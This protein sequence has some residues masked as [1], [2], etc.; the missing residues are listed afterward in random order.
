MGSK[1]QFANLGHST[2]NFNFF[3]TQSVSRSLTLSQ[4]SG[5]AS[6]QGGSG[7]LMNK[8]ISLSSE[9]K[10]QIVD[11]VVSKISAGEFTKEVKHVEEKKSGNKSSMHTSEEYEKV[12]GSNK[13]SNFEIISEEIDEDEVIEIIEKE[14]ASIS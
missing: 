12:F 7:G 8:L 4:G 14:E 6:K 11:S 5:S 10:F 9:G 1:I 2:S 13:T 3:V